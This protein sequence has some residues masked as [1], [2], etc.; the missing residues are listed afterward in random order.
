MPESKTEILGVD[1]KSLGRAGFLL[2]AG[3]LVAFPT[4]TVYGLGAD[5]CN[6][7]AVASIFA[8]KARPSFNPLIVHVATLE[9]AK[10]IAVFSEDAKT[11]AERFWPGPLTLV[12]PLREK[13]GISPLVSAG[14]PS[15]AI[16]IPAHPVARQLLTLFGGPVA[17][18]SAN[19]SGRLS[20][21]LADHVLDGL[22]GKIAA[23]VDAGPCA[24]G[25]ESTIVGFRP[26]PVLLRPGGVPVEDLA[27]CLNKPIARPDTTSPTPSAPGQLASHY[28]PN[29]VLRLNASQPHEGE[30]MLGFGNTP[31][32]LNLSES[33]DLIEASA[34]LF[35]HLREL[36][37]GN[38][39]CIAVSPI[40]DHGL[41]LA[42]NDRLKRAAAPRS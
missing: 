17:G 22:A 18:P 12:L 41:G 9:M 11:L 34:N 38:I 31:C 36:D 33:G 42:I 7:A 37:S 26:G 15:I 35:H 14:L 1:V 28:A 24:V 25:L 40:P 27:D 30:V 2:R 3:R 13:T 4:E 6:D 21:T 8:A 20:P 10:D 5:A 23:V 39:R 19:P 32:D 29:A 16:R